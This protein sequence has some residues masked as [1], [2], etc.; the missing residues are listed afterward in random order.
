MCYFHIIII[1]KI[2]LVCSGTPFLD[3]VLE[4]GDTLYLPRGTVHQAMCLEDVHSLH[5][6]VSCNQLNTWGDL[7]LKLVPTALQ[8]AMEESTEFR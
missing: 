2:F 4:A 3:V 8:T 6:T 7:L 1:I 5:I